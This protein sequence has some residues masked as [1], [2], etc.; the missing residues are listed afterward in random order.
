MFLSFRAGAA[1]ELYKSLS[2]KMN[3][4]MLW[5]RCRLGKLAR[6]SIALISEHAAAATASKGLAS[7]QPT[8]HRARFLTAKRQVVSNGDVIGIDEFVNHFGHTPKR[9]KTDEASC[10]AQIPDRMH[11]CPVPGCGGRF[12]SAG[13]LAGHLKCFLLSDKYCSI[14]E[15]S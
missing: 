4:G 14:F 10:P 3:S 5:K 2:P 9:A 1:R 11:S 8:V 7:A 12:T 6:S 15:T 13:A